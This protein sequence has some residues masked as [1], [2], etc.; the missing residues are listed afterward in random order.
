MH[1]T[2]TLPRPQ[3][4]HY[5]EWAN[6]LRCALYGSLVWMSLLYT[7]LVFTRTLHP[8]DP[9]PDRCTRI[10]LIGLAPSMLLCGGLS[11]WHLNQFMA[12][13]L[14]AFRSAPASTS[15]ISPSRQGSS[16]APPCRCKLVARGRVLGAC[17][18]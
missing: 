3:K 7:I 18:C 8:G 9:V 13:V 10:M 12:R 1:P 14:T 5:N 11:Y 17:H 6:H 15:Q 4:P 2:E 16:L